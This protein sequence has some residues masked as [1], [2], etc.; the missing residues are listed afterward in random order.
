[1]SLFPRLNQSCLE[2]SNIRLK[3]VGVIRKTQDRIVLTRHGACTSFRSPSGFPANP[4]VLALP[5]TPSVLAM[6]WQS[7]PTRVAT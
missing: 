6:T 4:S 1:M 2:C 7:A 3:Y 5:A